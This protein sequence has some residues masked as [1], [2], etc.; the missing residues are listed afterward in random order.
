VGGE[1]G[2]DYSAGGS[3]SSEEGDCALP[4]V[5]ARDVVGLLASS[6]VVLRAGSRTRR[7]HEILQEKDMAGTGVDDVGHVVAPPVV[8]H[9]SHD[10]VGHRRRRPHMIIVAGQQKEGAR[11]P[12]DRDPRGVHLPRF[13][14]RRV[15]EHVGARGARPSGVPGPS[16]PTA[17]TRRSAS[18]TAAAQARRHC[19]VQ[20]LPEAAPCSVAAPHSIR[21]PCRTWPCL[22]PAGRLIESG[23]RWSSGLARWAIPGRARLRVRPRRP[24]RRE[25][26][27]RRR[28]RRRRER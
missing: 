2:G 12:L 7:R 5:L 19:V 28:R 14:P 17:A 21:V 8:L 27:R 9:P 26:L 22:R 11:R 10:L 23:R 3:R 24:P 25:D 1:S 20:S 18:R 16:A 6:E 13:M 4:R 15:A